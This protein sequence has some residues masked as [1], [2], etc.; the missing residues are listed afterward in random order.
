MQRQQTKLVNFDAIWNLEFEM[1]YLK[2]TQHESQES[3]TVYK[4]SKL[5]TSLMAI[6]MF[7]R[8]INRSIRFDCNEF[9]IL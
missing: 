2:S 8:S 9:S 7:W 6:T 3:V 4:T 5:T 1:L